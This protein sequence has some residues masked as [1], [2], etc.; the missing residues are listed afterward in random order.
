MTAL[1]QASTPPRGMPEGSQA[2]RADE[3][4][5]TRRTVAARRALGAVV[6]LALLILGIALSLSVG[7]NPL[8]LSDVW[9]SIVSP[10]GSETSSIVWGLR[11]PR[12]LVAIVAGAAFGV[13]GAL[14]QAMTRNP[15][16]DPGILGVNAGAGFAVV[17]GVGFFGVADIMGYVWCAMIGAV[18]A[19]VL[20]YLVGAAGSSS[21]SPVTLVLAGIALT[22]VLMAFTTFLT[23]IDEQTFQSFRRWGLGSVARTTVTETLT[24][25]PFI[26]LGILIALMI[27][28]SL[29]AVALG[30]DQAVALGAN[31]MRTR[32]L[33]IVAV[34]LL[35]GAG[36]ALTGGIAFIGLAVPHLVRWFTGPDQ[37]WIIV[38][39]ALAAGVLVLAAD[40]LGRVI[41]RPGEMEAGVLT[42][43]VGA[44]VLIALVRRKKASG[45]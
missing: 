35:A 23:L 41:V 32:V 8:S 39:T 37:R 31:V 3:H 11:V 9:R 17:L 40:V 16:A 20:V 21:P 28:T 38:Y 36:T 4:G 12:T 18:V 10:D 24:V 25:V 1:G 2:V 5:S 26:A 45:L 27:A 44:P 42:A 33:G 34:T 29:N 14:I 7:A 19:T 22:A 43:L 6:L 15:L 13:A 30:D